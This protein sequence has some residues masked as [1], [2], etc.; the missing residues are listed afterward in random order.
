[1]PSAQRGF[2]QGRIVR[3]RFIPT[4][5]FARRMF[6][7]YLGLMPLAIE[8]LDLAGYD[9]VISSN[10]AVAKGVLTGP[11]QVHISYVHSPMRYAWDLQEQYL[12]QAGIRGVKGIYARWLF[13]R[14]R[15]WD[16]SSAHH[17]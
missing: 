10:H 1:M 12:S 8:Q 6:R 5:P 7:S 11:D 16:V 15:Q 4:L 3:P 9:L 13:A 17:V 2:L 14:L